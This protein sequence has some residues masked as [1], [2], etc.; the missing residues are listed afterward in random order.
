MPLRTPLLLEGRVSSGERVKVSLSST[1]LLDS[2]GS[3][4]KRIFRSNS[5]EIDVESLQ[6]HCCCVVLIVWRETRLICTFFAIKE[7]LSSQRV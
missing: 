5:T 2:Y 1:R 3:P 7:R 4:Q 6:S